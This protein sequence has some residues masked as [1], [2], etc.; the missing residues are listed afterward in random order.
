MYFIQIFV[1]TN[2]DVSVFMRNL[3][4][5]LLCGSIMC[6]FAVS[7]FHFIHVEVVASYF[8]GQL[9]SASFYIIKE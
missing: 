9:D 7:F 5:D 2:T 6:R 8:V 3:L 4:S 1:C